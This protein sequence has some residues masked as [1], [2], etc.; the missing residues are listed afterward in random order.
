MRNMQ[1]TFARQLRGLTQTELASKIKGLS[2]SNLS[3]F[4]K[5]L[6]TLSDDILKKVMDVLGFPFSFLDLEIQN[7]IESKH[8]RKKASIKAAQRD[9]IDTTIKI[10]SYVYDWMSEEIEFPEFKFK[11]ID[12]MD[13]FTPSNV[14]NQV[15]RQFRLGNAPLKDIFRFLEANGVSIYEW[16]CDFDDFDAVSLC[17]DK[18]NHIVVLNESLS[19]DRKRFSLAHE[20][21]H[22]IMH[23]SFDFI[24]SPIRDLEK[25]AHE[26]ASEL[27]MPTEAI[28]TSLYNIKLRDVA[29]LKDYWLT[30]MAAI[31]QKAKSTGSISEEKYIF[32]RTELSRRGWIKVEPNQVDIDTPSAI[33][34]ALSLY[35]NELNYSNL[36]LS[37]ATSL[38]LDIIESLFD[39][40]SNIVRL[41]PKTLTL[42]L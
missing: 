39:N 41:R 30:S 20:L 15:R 31:I 21:G 1:M 11:Q 27:L 14:A 38:P 9:L 32:L 18:G 36:E 34:K 23:Q 29:L 4:E 26:F 2:Q 7:N 19:N 3:K 16:K 37:E 22:I 25:E 6:G 33:S 28:R 17:T 40:N 5:G 42:S 24:L 12:L 35:R 8:F 13:G 10:I